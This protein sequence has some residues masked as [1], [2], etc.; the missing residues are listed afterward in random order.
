MVVEKILKYPLLFE[1][2]YSIEHLFCSR[3]HCS[4][5]QY[6]RIHRIHY[7]RASPATRRVCAF[8]FQLV[9]ASLCVMLFLFFNF[10]RNFSMC[11]LKVR[12]ESRVIPRYVGE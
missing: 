9:P 4:S 7:T 6:R 11:C 8:A 12:D 5:T 10:S 2:W 1:V 3:V